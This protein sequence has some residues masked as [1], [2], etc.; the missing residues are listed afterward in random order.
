MNAMLPRRRSVRAATATHARIWQVGLTALTI[1]VSAA[2]AGCTQTAQTAQAARPGVTSA[3]RSSSPPRAPAASS[4][5]LMTATS[6][7]GQILE[8]GSGVPVYYFTE[9]SVSASHCAGTCVTRWQPLI[10]TGRLY[11]AAG[12]S[13]AL[14]GHIVRPGGSLQL[15]YA[16]HA[17]YTYSQDAAPGQINGQDVHAFG[18]TWLVVSASGKAGNQHGP[19]PTASRDGTGI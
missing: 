5:T 19:T 16:G 18:G 7:Y 17:L 12:V 6:A 10:L 2:A 4:V 15:S 8:T 11:L 13:A 14:V 3:P 9:D 1:A